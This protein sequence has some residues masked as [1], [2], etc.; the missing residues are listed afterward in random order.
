MRSNLPLIILIIGR[1]CHAP[2]HILTAAF[3][4]FVLGWSAAPGAQNKPTLTPAD[5]DQPETQRERRRAP[6]PACRVAPRRGQLM[7]L[8]KSFDE[9]VS[10]IRGTKSALVSEYTPY[11]MD[12]SIGR[13]RTCCSPISRPAHARR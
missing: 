9:Q 13:E 4:A 8:G 10:P 12:R 1:E 3:V 5:Y 7:V 6:E 11:L 2:V